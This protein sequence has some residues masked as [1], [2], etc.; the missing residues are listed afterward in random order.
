MLELIRQ[1]YKVQKRPLLRP[2]IASPFAGASVQKVV[3]VSSKMP[4]MS[5]VKRV[6]K[7]LA[8]VEKRETQSAAAQVK[9]SKKRKTN[10]RGQGSDDLGQVA[11][12]LAEKKLKGDADGEGKNEVVMKGTGRAIEKALSLALWFQ[13]REEYKIHIETG[14]VGAIDDI[15]APDEEDAED[16]DNMKATTDDIPEA[17]VRHAS[18]VQVFVSLR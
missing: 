18:V 9:T 3:Y 8:Q 12:V 16:G 4:F 15:V 10:G 2:P 7:L 6:Q 13:Q 11:A 5:A 1:D 14:T 17:R